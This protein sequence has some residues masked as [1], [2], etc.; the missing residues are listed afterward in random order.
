[1]VKEKVGNN[2]FEAW[3]MTPLCLMW[4]VWRERNAR[5][6]LE[7][8]VEELK[9]V[10]FKSLHTWI[11]GYDSPFFIFKIFL[12]VFVPFFFLNRV[13]LYTSCVLGLRF[14]VLLMRLIYLLKK[15]IASKLGLMC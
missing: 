10:M 12:N 7:I 6:Y 9:H 15:K 2:I 4:C 14:F 8:S 11:M 1:V 5:C 3:R 13:F